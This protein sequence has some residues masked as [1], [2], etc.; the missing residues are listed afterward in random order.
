MNIDG[1]DVRRV[2]N[3][4]GYD[5]G[6]FFSWDGKRIVYRAYH[7]TDSASVADYKSLLA[8]QLVRPTTMEIFV[9]DADGKQQRQLTRNGSAN[10]APFFHP[11]DRHII[12]AS[13]MKDPK[14]RGF[15][16]YLMKDDG[17]DLQQITFGGSFNAFPMFSKDGKHLVFVSD[18]NAKGRYEFNLFL[19]DWIN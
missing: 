14:G 19:A 1:S 2:T 17:S 13:N 16:L 8:D 6:G 5:G 12:F 7:Q 11:D 3:E 15:H 9:C 18:R 10:F 4:T